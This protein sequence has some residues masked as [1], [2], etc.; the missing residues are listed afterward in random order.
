MVGAFGYYRETG[1]FVV[2]KAKAVVL[3]TGG[4]GRMYKFTS[5]SW[6][7]TGDGLQMAYEAGAELMDMEMIQ[8]HPTGMAWPPGMRGILV[9]EGVRGEGGILRNNKG[10]RFM[11]NPDYMPALYKGQFAETR[12]GG[13]ALAGRQEEQPPPAGT[14]AARR[15][16]ARHLS[17]GRGRARH[18]A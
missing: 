13:R 11:F 1:K 18:G 6:E 15:R 8:F 16:V 7:G 14:A 3:A 17:R 5:N 10:E 12:G 2:F 9:T 4:W